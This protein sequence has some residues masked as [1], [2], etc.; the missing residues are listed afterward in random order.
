MI[1][2]IESKIKSLLAEKAVKTNKKGEEVEY[3][4]TF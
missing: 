1:K 2:F 4:T 3:E